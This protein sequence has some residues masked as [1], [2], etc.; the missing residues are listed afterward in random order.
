[1][2]LL[3]ILILSIP[4]RAQSLA[5]LLA[6]LSRQMTPEVE[7]LVALDDR[8]Q[9]RADK[10]NQLVGAAKG[11]YCCFVDDDDT[12]SPQYVGRLLAALESKPD[13]VGFRVAR[14]KGSELIGEAMHSLRFVRY[15]KTCKNDSWYEYE[16]PPNHLNPI[17]TTI[18]RD[19]P[20]QAVGLEDVDFACRVRSSL[21]TQAFVDD[22]LYHYVLPA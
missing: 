2:I 15:A 13:C 3:S 20:F 12:V 5:R 1:M 6:I 7:V 8:A 14:Y 19:F 16:R 22:V 17:R 4:S 11:D 21:F 10:R 18:V 9:H